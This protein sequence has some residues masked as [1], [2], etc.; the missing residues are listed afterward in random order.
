M[1]TPDTSNEC[2][3]EKWI[4]ARSAVE[5]G[6]DGYDSDYYEKRIP[7]RYLPTEKRWHSDK[8]N[9]LVSNEENAD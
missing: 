7:T 3:E 2:W 9:V 1:T 8:R 6:E 4:T 5:N